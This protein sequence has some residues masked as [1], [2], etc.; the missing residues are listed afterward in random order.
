MAI[1][2]APPTQLGIVAEPSSN[3]VLVA[4][5]LLSWLVVSRS[6]DG[7]NAI[8]LFVVIFTVDLPSVALPDNALYGNTA[9]PLPAARLAPAARGKS[10]P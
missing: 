2:L 5:V 3:D 10:S 1:A 6:I 8:Q 7:S 4:P 9:P